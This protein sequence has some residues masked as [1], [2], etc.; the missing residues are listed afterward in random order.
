MSYEKL[1]E[2]RTKY[3]GVRQRKWGKWVSEIKVSYSQERLWLGSYATAEAAAVTHD[4]VL[5]CLRR[6][7]SL[8]SLNFPLMLLVASL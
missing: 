2:T 7:V 1:K 3:R 6:S 8:E 4:V 5:Y